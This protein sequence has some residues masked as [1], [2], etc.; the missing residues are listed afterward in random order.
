MVQT[1][2]HRK[3]N[4]AARHTYDIGYKKW[5]HF[6]DGSCSVNEE[7]FEKAT[8]DTQ[9]KD[10]FY[11]NSSIKRENGVTNDVEE[12]GS[13][14]GTILRTSMNNPLLKST[15]KNIDEVEREHGNQC[16]RR[17]EWTQAI[18]NY[19]RSIGFNPS[20]VASYS[21]RAMA[22]LKL[23]AF[24]DSEADCCAALDIDPLHVKSLLRRATARNALGRHKAAFLD[25]TKVFKLDSNNRQAAALHDKTRELILASVRSASTNFIIVHGI[26]YKD[27]EVMKFLKAENQQDSNPLTTYNKKSDARCFEK[28]SLGTLS[29]HESILSNNTPYVHKSLDVTIATR[30]A[31]NVG[32]SSL[33][34]H[35]PST[36]YEFECVWNQLKDSPH[37]R[38][39]LIFQ[40]LNCDDLA[41]LFKRTAPEADMLLEMILCMTNHL[42]S[43]SFSLASEYY[44]NKILQVL[45]TLAV[46][47][48]MEM[49]VS[50]LTTGE[51]AKIVQLLNIVS[52]GSGDKKTMQIL[53]CFS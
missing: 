39:E 6:D 30:I 8:S 50:F 46:I 17:H 15:T 18:R 9:G 19:T 26:P 24:Q 4:S 11:A 21:N 38:F 42:Q 29:K 13:S 10:V 20:N 5:D 36:F 14:V 33:L 34:L 23:K 35:P 7:S 52:C 27:C 2:R 37:M 41:R 43:D 32:K 53:R 3:D 48:G 12:D 1:D 45:Y 44:K 28:N 49:T 25:I 51:K 16:F 40:L 31:S 47:P 22:Y